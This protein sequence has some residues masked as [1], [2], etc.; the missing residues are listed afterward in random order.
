[1][2][3]L[4]CVIRPFGNITGLTITKLGNASLKP[5]ARC[6]RWLKFIEEISENDLELANFLQ[7]FC[8]YLLSGHRDEQIILFLHGTIANG[9]SVFLSILK[10]VLG[11]YAGVI[12]SKA[13]VEA[14]VL[15]LAI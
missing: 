10:H 6:E 3:L 11:T 5:E 8:G 12:S 14:P 9:K 4:T 7:K 13:L 15:F 1:M 2:G